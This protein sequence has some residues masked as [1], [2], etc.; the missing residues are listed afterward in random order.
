MVGG[1]GQLGVPGPAPSPWSPAS[2]YFTL[3]QRHPLCRG[4]T[5]CFCLT[6]AVLEETL[7]SS[8]V[9]AFFSSLL[10]PSLHLPFTSSVMPSAPQSQQSPSQT[11]GR[12]QAAFTSA[13][14]FSRP[15]FEGTPRR[16]RKDKKRSDVETSR[17]IRPPLSA[18][19]TFTSAAVFSD[20]YNQKKHQQ[21][22]R[23]AASVF[24]FFFAKAVCVLLRK[25]GQSGRKGQMCFSALMPSF[26][27]YS[28]RV[29]EKKNQQR[30]EGPKHRRQGVRFHVR[31]FVS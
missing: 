22:N 8:W 21:N 19:K 28:A 27:L 7:T 30:E 23:F 9:F 29:K 13:A 3:C 20:L 17:R 14:S 10:P 16:D 5:S 2:R 1:R 25:E 4:A 15:P 12:Q 24:F 31:H 6:G 11:L 18:A 26:V